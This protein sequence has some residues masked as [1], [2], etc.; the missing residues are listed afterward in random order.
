MEHFECI[1]LRDGNYDECHGG[2]D[3]CG[4]YGDCTY[5]SHYDECDPNSHDVMCQDD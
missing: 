2:C 5:C 4:Y 1:F 3:V